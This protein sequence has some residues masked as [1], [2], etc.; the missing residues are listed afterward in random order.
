MEYFDVDS[1][2]ELPPL[3]KGMRY[4]DFLGGTR[5]LR[6]YVV[7]ESMP[8]PVFIDKNEALLDESMHPIYKNQ[9]ISVRQ[10][11]SHPVPGFYIVSAT[12]FFKSMDSMDE[13][14]HLRL[15]MVL[16]EVRKAMRE[17][18]KLPYVHL[19]Y[20]ERE[21]QGSN[22]HYWLLPIMDIN[23]NPRIYNFD[24]KKYLDSFP[25]EGARD[26]IIALNHKMRSHLAETRLVEK[27]N[28]LLGQ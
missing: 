8:R 5:F 20:E 11:S 24:I 12:K 7:P 22:V 21:A 27:D 18:I 26:R 13:Q 15:F 28:A 6:C 19:Y 23:E 10:D 17:V 2:K 3:Q 14:T 25:F 16:R 1:L 4:F 9:G